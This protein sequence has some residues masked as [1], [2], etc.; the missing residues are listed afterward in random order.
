MKDVDMLSFINIYDHSQKI[1]IRKLGYF[2]NQ[3]I[4]GAQ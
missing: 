2:I 3:Q 1:F 4:V